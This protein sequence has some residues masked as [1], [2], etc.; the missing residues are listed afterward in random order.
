[1]WAVGGILR[2]T[3]ARRRGGDPCTHCEWTLGLCWEGHKG[4]PCGPV[5]D[6]GNSQRR[7][8]YN[9]GLGKAACGCEA[10]AQASNAHWGPKPDRATGH[11][12]ATR[13]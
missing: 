4:T 3:T 8:R 5:G 2:P 10:G 9:N 12:W 7:P 6:E 1:M 11:G 13:Y